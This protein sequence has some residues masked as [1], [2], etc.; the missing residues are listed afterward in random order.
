MVV[1]PMLPTVLSLLQ[2]A[3]LVFILAV[4][5]H[6]FPVVAVVFVLIQLCRCA[7]TC[8]CSWPATTAR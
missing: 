4:R 2:L 7:A 5:A 1:E 8:S 3:A 6:P